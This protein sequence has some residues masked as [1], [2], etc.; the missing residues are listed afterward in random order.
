MAE[1]IKL[2]ILCITSNETGSRIKQYLNNKRKSCLQQ[3][4][5]LSNKDFTL[6]AITKKTNDNIA[7]IIK[8]VNHETFLIIL[9]EKK[10]QDFFHRERSNT[11]LLLTNKKSEMITNTE[12]RKRGIQ[13]GLPKKWEIKNDL[14]HEIKRALERYFS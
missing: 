4:K 6:Q 8:G 2:T 9:E 14:Y 12:L 13:R 7:K 1:S 5:S 11:V 10:D 3:E